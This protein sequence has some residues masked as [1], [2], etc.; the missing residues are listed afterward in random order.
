MLARD[1]YYGISEPKI[2]TYIS[3][4]AMKS[5]C[6]KALIGS[7]HYVDNYRLLLN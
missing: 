1:C 6:G 4:F 5:V 2:V 3:P 7:K